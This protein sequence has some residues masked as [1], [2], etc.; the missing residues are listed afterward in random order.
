VTVNISYRL[1]KQRAAVSS[2]KRQESRLLGSIV[3]T[4]TEKASLNTLQADILRIWRITANILNKRRV[5]YTEVVPAALGEMS[6][7]KSV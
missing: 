4:V 5:E 7:P 3:Q 6:G 1:R 2:M